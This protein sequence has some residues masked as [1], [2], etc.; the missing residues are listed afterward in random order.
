MSQ[1]EELG[2]GE[3]PLA[4]VF[5]RQ[6]SFFAEDVE[7]VNAFYKHL[8]GGSPY[9][10]ACEAVLTGINEENPP[11]PIALW[12]GIDED[13]RDLLVGLTKLVPERRVTAREA[14]GYRWFGDVE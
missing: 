8:G 6:F 9:I 7:A 10:E 12:R 5:D 14:L 1:R 13:L 2:E 11:K 3:I 4:H